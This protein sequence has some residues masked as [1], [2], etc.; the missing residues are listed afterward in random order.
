MTSCCFRVRA[1]SASS[2]HWRSKEVAC[3]RYRYRYRNTTSGYRDVVSEVGGQGGAVMMKEERGG[4]AMA[5]RCEETNAVAAR[6]TCLGFICFVG[7][8]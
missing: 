6:C 8:L 5:W 2:V 4:R 3:Y 7:S 1:W